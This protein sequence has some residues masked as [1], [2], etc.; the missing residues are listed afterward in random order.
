MPGRPLHLAAWNVN[1]RT[2]RKAIPATVLHAIATLDVDVLVLT[3][4]VDGPHHAEFRNALHDLGF[5]DI[6][7]SVKAPHQNQVLIASRTPM[8][9]D[10]L[11]AAPGYTEAA[12]TNWLHRRLPRH[13]LEIVGLRAP[14]YLKAPD[15]AGYWR[16]VERIARGARARALVLIGDFGT[17][18]HTDTRPC[19]EPCR[20]LLEDGYQLPIA[21]GAWSYRADDGRTTRVDHALAAPSVAIAETRY[22]YRAGRH[23]LAGQPDTAPL[24]DHA[25]LSIRLQSSALC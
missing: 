16:Q 8:A 3:E 24:S 10:D 20:R 4:F 23:T 15:R 7:V 2:G 5:A 17:D 22:L 12:T 1:H 14:T 21:D 25:V 6:A 13:G 19:M 9:S 11:I 18:P